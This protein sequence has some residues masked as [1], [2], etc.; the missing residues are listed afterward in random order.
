M[1]PRP[2]SDDVLRVLEESQRLGF[3]GDRP[4]PE[5]V[6][7]SRRF[8]IA[9]ASVTGTVVDLGSGG[10]VPGLVI[11]HDRPDLEMVL[12]DR[13]SKRTDFLS[14]MVLRL[15]WS[16]HVA[17]LDEDVRQVIAR[18]PETFDAAVAR[19]FGPA[20]MTLRFA[21]RLVR[22]GGRI[23]I[24]EPPSGERWSVDLAS[25]LGVCR[26]EED[27]GSVAVFERPGFT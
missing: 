14:R 6:E 25:E 9:L 7:H 18:S 15:G 20:D 27:L 16:D 21:S 4:I 19:G 1:A 22:P 11:A 23:V 13:R 17:V 26:V 2:S 3:L 5:V 24:S 8:V 10:G 12:I